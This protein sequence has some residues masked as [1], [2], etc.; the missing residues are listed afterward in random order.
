M[1]AAFGLSTVTIGNDNPLDENPV[2]ENQQPDINDE[3]VI[4]LHGDPLE[5][6]R[7]PIEGEDPS[8]TCFAYFLLLLLLI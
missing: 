3:A 4:D 8:G 5:R 7:L 2:V 6:H 1:G